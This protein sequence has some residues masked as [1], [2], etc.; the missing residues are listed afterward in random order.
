M[1]RVCRPLLLLIV[2]CI[3]GCSEGNPTLPEDPVDQQQ[4]ISGDV[5][6]ENQTDVDA[7]EN[8]VAVLGNLSVRLNSDITSLAG[9]HR[10]KIV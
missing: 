2:I 5:I 3:T 4:T 6:L 7:M 1:L 8:V 10:I 9:L